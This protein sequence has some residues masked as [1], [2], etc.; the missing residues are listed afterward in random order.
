MQYGLSIQI[1]PQHPRNK[2]LDNYIHQV[3]VVA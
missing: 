1:R 2:S 3:A